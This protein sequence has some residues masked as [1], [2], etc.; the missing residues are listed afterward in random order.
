VGPRFGLIVSKKI[1]KR[2]SRRNF[3]KRRL[4]EIIRTQLLQENGTLLLPY[5]A[6]VIVARHASLGASYEEMAQKLVHCF[7][8]GQ[9]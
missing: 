7:Q 8:K 4:R 5:G 6:I 9:P 2:S 3:I 1:D